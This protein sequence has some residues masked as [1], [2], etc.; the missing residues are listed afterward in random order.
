MTENLLNFHTVQ[1]A[2]SLQE[3]GPNYFHI[4]CNYSSRVIS[5]EQ[6]SLNQLMTQEVKCILEYLKIVFYVLLVV[7]YYMSSSPFEN[8]PF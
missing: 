1:A 5:L 6:F 3:M 4:K 7:F 2:Q 8:D